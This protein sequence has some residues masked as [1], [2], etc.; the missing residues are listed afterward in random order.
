MFDLSNLE[1]KLQNPISKFFDNIS[2]EVANIGYWCSIEIVGYA[3]LETLYRIY[4]TLTLRFRKQVPLG[5]AI[6]LAFFLEN[7]MQNTLANYEE[8]RREVYDEVT[9][10]VTAAREDLTRRNVMK[11]EAPRWVTARDASVDEECIPIVTMPL[12]SMAPKTS[13]RNTPTSTAIVLYEGSTASSSGQ[14]RY[15]S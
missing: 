13:L 15:W 6:S 11:E 14:P 8:S 10:R 4:A 12:P 5:E 3:A 9:H 7:R 2:D 1:D